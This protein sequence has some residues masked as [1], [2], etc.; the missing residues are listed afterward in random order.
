MLIKFWICLI[1]LFEFRKRSWNDILK[2]WINII[3][4]FVT[5]RVARVSPIERINHSQ[6]TTTGINKDALYS[7]ASFQSPSARDFIFNTLSRS[8]NKLFI[9]NKRAR[10]APEKKNNATNIFIHCI[11]ASSRFSDSVECKRGKT[12]ASGFSFRF[13]RVEGERFSRFSIFQL[14]RFNKF[15][16][17]C[18]DGNQFSIIAR[19]R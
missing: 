3:S 2:E 11:C 15:R 12:K 8:E 19:K 14:E 1:S 16:L 18:V 7:H 9:N 17:T 5:S 13:S 4:I 6:F 10:E